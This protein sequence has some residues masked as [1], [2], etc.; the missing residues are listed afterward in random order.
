MT[1]NAVPAWATAL[2]ETMNARFDQI[3]HRLERLEVATDRMIAA[4][5][6]LEAQLTD[7]EKCPGLRDGS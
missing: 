7:L 4:V 2:V 3:A 5:N 1:D 6:E